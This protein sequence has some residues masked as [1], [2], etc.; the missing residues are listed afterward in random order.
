MDRIPEIIQ[1][2]CSKLYEGIGQTN[3]YKKQKK[4]EAFI[5]FSTLLYK[6]FGHKTVDQNFIWEFLTY[7]M[8]CLFGRKTRFDSMVML[9]WLLSEKSIE[10]WNSRNLQ[11]SEYHSNEFLERY[12]IKKEMWFEP[13]DLED[14]E[15]IERGRFFNT[16]LG[17]VT[18]QS[19]ASYNEYS[20]YCKKCKFKEKCKNEK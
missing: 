7:N 4:N 19:L 1:I 6:H 12:G 5:R 9:N 15:D 14:I 10:R 17:W 20:D 13:I 2:V 11:Y 18:C 16:D 3:L 8:N